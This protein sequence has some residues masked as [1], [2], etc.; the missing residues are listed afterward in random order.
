MRKNALIVSPQKYSAIAAKKMQDE[1]LWDP[2]FFLTSPGNKPF[3]EQN[4]PNITTLN[5]INSV[6]GRGLKGLNYNFHHHI[7]DDIELDFTIAISLLD[8][9][10]SNSKTF[11]Y[12]ERLA[13]CH[14]RVSFWASVLKQFKIEVVLFEEEPHQCSD[15]IL[16]KVAQHFGIKTPM[17]VRTIADLGIIPTTKFELKSP[18]F[19][20]QYSSLK[21]THN[22]SKQLDLTPE[23]MSY[24]NK[25]SGEYNDVLKEHL[26]NQLDTF[27]EVFVKE[28]TKYRLVV[29]LMKKL[30]GKIFRYKSINFQSDQKQSGQSFSNSELGYLKYQYYKLKTYYKKVRLYKTYKSLATFPKKGESSYVLCALQY[31]PEKSTCPL[32]GKYN[33]QRL[34]IQSLRERLPNEIKI[35]VKEHPSQFIYDFAR[36]GEDFRD[37]SYYESILSL[38]NVELLDMRTNIFDMIDDALFVA[39]VTGTIGWEAVNRKTPALCFGHSWMLGCEGVYA[40]AKSNDINYAIEA[41]INR[42]EKINLAHVHLFAQTIFNLGFQLAVGGPVQLQKKNRT[43]DENAQL[44]YNALRWLE[45]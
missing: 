7:L 44:L 3:I 26:W 39:S 13:F 9:N 38:P 21:K 10:D 41:I 15:Y 16:Y 2:V 18:K 19:I 40:V 20:E 6:K 27:E 23:L 33:N 28:N 14:E 1:G 11:M 34:M 37:K 35:Y 45:V 5:Y 17:V 32:G 30:F 25:L 22:T 36:Y 8:R 29:K 12:K 4:F 31:Q 43:E 42:K 24:L